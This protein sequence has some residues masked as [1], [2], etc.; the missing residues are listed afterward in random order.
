MTGT[1][2]KWKPPRDASTMLSVRTHA[3]GESIV[4]ACPAEGDPKPKINWY[5]NGYEL[6]LN[7][8]V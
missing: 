4:L 2:P 3:A 6:G 5:K 1:S 7:D 8:R